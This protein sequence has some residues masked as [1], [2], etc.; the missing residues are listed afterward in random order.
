MIRQYRK[1]Y[2]G[3]T[4][5]WR[6]G[7]RKAGSKNKKPSS[8]QKPHTFNQHF[9]TL[10]DDEEKRLDQYMKAIR[11][12]RINADGRGT[13]TDFVRLAV[14]SKWRL[15][16]IIGIIISASGGD[17]SGVL[18]YL[19]GGTRKSNIHGSKVYQWRRIDCAYQNACLRS[20]TV[21]TWTC[22]FRVWTAVYKIWNSA[23]TEVV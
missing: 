6:R 12:V 15:I 23:T 10:S 11:E 18:R 3:A 8:S 13:L 9:P 14:R 17:L 5:A 1:S 19:K 22:R 16:E 21:W 20:L 2:T 4:E 7:G